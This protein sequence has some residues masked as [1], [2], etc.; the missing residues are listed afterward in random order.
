MSS[1]RIVCADGETLS[2]MPRPKP[3]VVH[4]KTFVWRGEPV[5]YV[6]RAY[7][8]ADANALGVETSPAPDNP[9]LRLVCSLASLVDDEFAS[10]VSASELDARFPRRPQYR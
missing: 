1:L 8:R 7:T 6:C 5:E 10:P 9:N 3:I 2:A 4:V